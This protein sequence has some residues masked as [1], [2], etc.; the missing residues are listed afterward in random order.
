MSEEEAATQVAEETQAPAEEIEGEETEQNAEAAP[1]EESGPRMFT[2]KE[3]GEEFEVTEEELLRGFQRGRASTRKFE[4][5]AKQ[6][7]EIEQLLGAMRNPKTL[8]KVLKQ[9]GVDPDEFAESYVQQRLAEES[10]P[11]E[12][13]RAKQLAREREEFERQRKE[14][15]E[16][17]DQ[18]K[19]T[20]AQKREM[21]AYE[22]EFTRVL[23]TSGLPATQDTIA[24]IATVMKRALEAGEDLSADDAAAI[25]REQI[26]SNTQSIVRSMSP[27]QLERLLGQEALDKLRKH[28]VGRVRTAQATRPKA[29]VK[30]QTS[31]SSERYRV[32]EKSFKEIFGGG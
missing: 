6:R 9:L 30:K 19:L 7:K 1:P 29:K 8:P 4:A 17:Q 10:M 27:S 3:G 2:V 14:F 20:A 32:G 31:D 22:A 12:E 16:K 26:E 15:Q 18:L 5:A 28:D 25:Y 23:D 21:E 24:G 13:R 11:E